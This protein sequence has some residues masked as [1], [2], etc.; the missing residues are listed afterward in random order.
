[1]RQ[2]GKFTCDSVVALITHRF[3]RASM[4]DAITGMLYFA[5]LAIMQFPL[6]MNM[7]LDF[8]AFLQKICDTYQ[9]VHGQFE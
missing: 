6:M 1:M 4:Q 5:T 8:D 9:D 7:Q 2:D 3:M